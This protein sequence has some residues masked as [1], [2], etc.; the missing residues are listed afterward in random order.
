MDNKVAF[1]H[2]TKRVAIEKSILT[3]RLLSRELG[4]TV[5][6]AK[7]LLALYLDDP[8]AQERGVS[9]VYL[10]SGY[11]R[12]REEP[13]TSTSNGGPRD[14]PD[15]AAAA[16]D[17]DEPPSSQPRGDDERDVVQTRTVKLVAFSDLEATLSLFSPTPSHHVYSLTPAPLAPSDFSQL[18][19]TYL[20]LAASDPKVT[21]KWKLAPDADAPGRGYGGIVAWDGQ[22]GKK[23]TGKLVRKPTV[24]DTANKKAVAS[25]SNVKGKGK[26]KE[27]APTAATATV[28]AAKG[29]KVVTKKDKDKEDKKKKK[30]DAKPAARPI[31]QLG[32]LFS[33]QFAA[34]KDESSEEEASDEEEE[35]EEVKPKKGKAKPVVPAKRKSTSPVVTRKAPPAPASRTVTKKTSPVKPKAKAADI[36]IDD[37]DDDDWAMMDEEAMAEMEREANEKVQAKKTATVPA[38]P[39]PKRKAAEMMAASDN[40]DDDPAMQVDEDS[41]SKHSSKAPSS[42]APSRSASTSSTTT[43]TGSKS[44]TSSGPKAQ[45]SLNSFFKK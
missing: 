41:S 6:Q 32:G 10:V 39:A 2:I 5:T 7:S 35:E 37:D 13:S 11:L 23:R 20:P 24:E 45:G 36:E 14:E 33:R 29:K 25:A 43:K 27:D 12:P 21:A 17:L 16:M 28:S 1:R 26:A 9:A 4:V 34:K 42:A 22:E 3:Y 44:T 40:D 15:G 19:T 38:A 18:T 8:S 31:G 30:Q